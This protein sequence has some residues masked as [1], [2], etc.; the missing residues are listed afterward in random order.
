MT[1]IDL[2]AAVA[3]KLA[4]NAK[5]SYVQDEA[6]GTLVKVDPA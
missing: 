2:Q 1:G 4:K 5:R 3:Q 6:S